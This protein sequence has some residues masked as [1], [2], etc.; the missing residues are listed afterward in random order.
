MTA[1]G[2]VLVRRHGLRLQVVRTAVPS[3]IAIDERARVTRACATASPRHPPSSWPRSRSTTP[4]GD[5]PRFLLRSLRPGETQEVHTV[6]PHSRGVHRIGPLGVR[7][8]GPVRPDP[9]HRSPERRRRG[10]RAPPRAA[11]A[12][13]TLA[14]QRHRPGG[15]G[16]PTWSPCTERTTRPFAS[17]AT[18]TTCAASTGQPAPAPVSS[19][20][21]RRTDRPSASRHPRLTLHRA[22]GV[23]PSQLARV[24]RHD[25][26]LGHCARRRGRACRPPPHRRCR[27][28][29]RVRH[30]DSHEEGLET[31]L[32]SPR[33][34][35]ASACG[36]ARRERADLAG[37]SGR[38][39]RRP[40]RRRRRT[41]SRGPAATGFHRRGDRH[42]PG[43]LRWPPAARRGRR[44]RLSASASVAALHSNGW[45]ATVVDAQTTASLAWGAVV[46]A[47]SVGTQEPGPAHRGP[48]RGAGHDR[49]HHP[50][51]HAVHPEHVDAPELL[52]PW[53]L[54]WPS[55]AR[56]CAR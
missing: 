27:V 29:H 8:R 18:A 24:V 14:R 42:R 16:A 55:P 3:R 15:P 7:V 31:L 12:R 19:W 34:H 53:P 50:G 56:G 51:D 20:C 46:G 39:H 33:S 10:R 40:D 30:D 9:A 1:M 17:T 36:A 11:P 45:L 41:I 25:G 37:R 13:G 26:R 28:R 22:R 54:P 38:L 6:R 52:V 32:A 47:Q 4:L 35:R 21:A 43:I 48:A 23:G 2:L 5:R 49:R 44:R